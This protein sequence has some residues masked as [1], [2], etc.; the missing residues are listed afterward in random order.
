MREEGVC[1]HINH[2][3]SNGEE[4]TLEKSMYV[5][6]QHP[7]DTATGWLCTKKTLETSMSNKPGGKGEVMLFKKSAFKTE[8]ITEQITN[9]KKEHG[10]YSKEI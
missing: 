2:A 4:G 10:K 5:N 1:L 7:G 6:V 9:V 8:G 3:E